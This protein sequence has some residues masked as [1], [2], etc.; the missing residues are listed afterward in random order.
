MTN[1]QFC[2]FP[3][4]S[5]GNKNTVGAV[6]RLFLF[7]PPLKPHANFMNQNV[8]RWCVLL[9]QRIP[10]RNSL[11]YDNNLLLLVDNRSSAHFKGTTTSRLERSWPPLSASSSVS[12]Q[13]PLIPS[14]RDFRSWSWSP[15]LDTGLWLVDWL[16]LKN[17]KVSP[18][19][20][21]NGVQSYKLILRHWT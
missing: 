12:P 4:L 15:A 5:Y 18:I 14:S 20:F 17:E 19:Y 8:Q 7:D 13:T 6:A 9:W 10:I 16:E 21:W 1:D 11:S 3:M 2:L